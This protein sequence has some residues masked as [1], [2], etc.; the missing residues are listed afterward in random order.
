MHILSPGYRSTNV[1]AL[2]A[3]AGGG[4]SLLL[5]TG[6]A[7]AGNAYSLRKLRSAY[8]GSAIKVRRSSDNATQDI[9]FSGS[10]LDT[11]SLAS[12]VGAN[13]AYV[14]TWYD[15]V[16]SNNLTTASN[17]VQPR[18]VNA[19]A[20][21]TKN[22]KPSMVFDGT[23]D[24]LVATNPAGLAGASKFTVS[25]IVAATGGSRIVSFVTPG[26]SDYGAP[27]GVL[28]AYVNGS[29]IDTIRGYSNVT[30]AT[31][32]SGQ[33]FSG[34]TIYDATQAAITL[35]GTTTTP[36]SFS[37]TALTGSTSRFAVGSNAGSLGECLTG[38]VS[39][40]IVWSSAL[41][42]GDKATL[43]SNTKTYWGTP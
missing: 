27:D 20:L 35:D 37:E 14:D 18:I 16:G 5:D 15:Q 4:G 40:V 9:G 10:D 36:G 38:T 25:Y 43:V 22:S 6:I 42:S 26:G 41:G 12:F 29:T 28:P 30:G 34:F 17:S 8:A 33:L 21:D 19:G 2:Y 1:A 23:D 24:T 11:T 3:S 39:E 32:T 13:S 7:T 31:Y